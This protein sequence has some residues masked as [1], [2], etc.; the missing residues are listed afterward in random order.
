MLE[1]ER[2]ELEEAGRIKL[3]EI[4]RSLGLPEHAFETTDDPA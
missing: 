4:R 1:I 3:A 2:S